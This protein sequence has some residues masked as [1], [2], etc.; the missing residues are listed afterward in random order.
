M[1][2]GLEPGR[3]YLVDEERPGLSFSLLKELVQEG[4]RALILSSEPPEMVR[5]AHSL[6]EGVELVWVTEVSSPGALKPSMVDHMNAARERFLAMGERSAVLL[7][8][9]NQLVCANDFST[10][11]KFLNYIRDDTLGRDSVVLVSI[12]SMAVDVRHLRMV[13]RL[14]AGVLS[15]SSG[16][17]DAPP[18]GPIP[19]S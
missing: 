7:D 16:A 1:A 12:D 14:V 9:F 5:R 4:R 3:M 6:P 17:Q 15:E 2:R 18:G 11:F 10:V 13:R 19:R 8:V